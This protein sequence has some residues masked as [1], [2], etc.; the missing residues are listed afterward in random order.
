MKGIVKIAGAGIGSAD[1]IT[2]R[3][4]NALEEA[5]VIIY[6]RLL[7]EDLILPY[8][9]KKETYYAGKAASNHYLPQ[10]EINA[11]M[12]QKAKEGKTVLR[13][14]G[15]DPYIFGRGGE[16]AEYCVE[17]GVD[18]E[19]IPGV[20]SGVVSLMF[21]GIP[22]THRDVSTSVTFITGHRKRGC[23][24]NFHEYAKLNGTLVFYMG[25]KN[26]PI[27]TGDLL[28]GGM[29]PHRPCAVIM[30]GAYPYQ[31]VFTSTV[32]KVAE[33][34]KKENFGSPSLIVVGDVVTYRN[35]LN[36]Y[37]SRPLFGKTVV[38]T[39][40]RTQASKLVKLLEREGA[41]TVQAPTLEIQPMNE[42]ALEE[43]VKDFDASH[44]VLHS[45]NGA[46]FFFKA[47]L[48]H[49]DL[50]DLYG[51]KLCCVGS[52][53]AKYLEKLGLRPDVVPDRFVG[54]ELAEAIVKEGTPIKSIFLPRSAKTRTSLLEE[55]RALGELK[56]LPVYDSV[57]PEELAELP[58]NPDYILF[59]S[60]T[61]VENFLK[62]YGRET[63][64]KAKVISIGPVTTKTLKDWNIP[65]YGETKKATVEAMVEFLK[66]DVQ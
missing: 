60:S 19:V 28:E 43:A 29:D 42:G 21:A 16:E 64:L 46:E 31:R 59:M 34:I 44:L 24:G 51:V 7:N 13:L 35:T 11:L 41:H 30:N 62:A 45:I 4:M 36:F 49:R 23:V 57:M 12:V 56:D 18:F 53:T 61:T 17:H 3:A 5:D 9:D 39:R 48:K 50:R 55:Y 25:L 65:V 40:A 66:E 10:D 27:I 54:E 8:L 6:D 20:T 47:F 38:V 2:V 63:L 52:A 32:G 26:L 15:G 22:A 33:E 58:E 37:E 1:M 14:K